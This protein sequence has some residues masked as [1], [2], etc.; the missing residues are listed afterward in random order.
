M[1]FNEKFQLQFEIA[2]DAAE[3]G[4]MPNSSV[5]VATISISDDVGAF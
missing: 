1:E 4:V 5:S 3:L 2:S